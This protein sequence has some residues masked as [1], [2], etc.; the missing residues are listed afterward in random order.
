M[1]AMGTARGAGAS[2]QRH[3]AADY[4]TTAPNGREI[5]GEMGAAAPAVLGDESP[6]RPGP[7]GVPQADT[8]DE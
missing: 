8:S 2:E 5:V 4:L 3:Q 6:S 1:G 7:S